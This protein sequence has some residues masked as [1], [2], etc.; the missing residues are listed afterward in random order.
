MVAHNILDIDLKN[1]FVNLVDVHDGQRNEPK[2]T[3]MMTFTGEILFKDVIKTIREFVVDKKNKKIDL[4]V[5]TRSILII[6]L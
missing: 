4:Y 3:H 6:Y 1:K 2:V 5:K